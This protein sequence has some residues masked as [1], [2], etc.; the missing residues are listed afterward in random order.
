MIFYLHLKNVKLI[1]LMKLYI[2]IV[3]SYIYK[4]D[5]NLLIF[6]YLH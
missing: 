2:T 5:F 4:C 6:Y 1:L 3:L